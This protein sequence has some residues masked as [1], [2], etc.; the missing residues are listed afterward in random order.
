MSLHAAGITLLVLCAACS[1]DTGP[2]G[3]A[4]PEGPEGP[5]GPVGP[6]GN[7]NVWGDTV[8]FANEDWGPGT[9]PLTTQGG[10]VMYLSRAV[11]IEVPA[12]TEDILLSGV[13][14]VYMQ[15]STKGRWT[16]LPF[17]FASFGGGYWVHYRFE[18][19]AGLIRLHYFHSR[20]HPDTNVPSPGDATIPTR[21]FRWVVIEGNMAPALVA[22]G[23]DLR[24]YDQVTEFLATHGKR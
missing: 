12:I 19:E 10:T 20:N 24:D 21:M 11:E 23:V 3:P 8:T 1:G 16:P 5:E 17:D 6:S 13:V 9:Y 2:V 22:A 15:P 18:V 4:G 14:L 7:A